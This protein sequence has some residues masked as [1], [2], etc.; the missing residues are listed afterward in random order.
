MGSG[1]A[2]E[3]GEAGH[4]GNGSGHHPD[5]VVVFGVTAQAVR[6]VEHFAERCELVDVVWDRF[7]HD[8]Q[9]LGE[10]QVVRLVKATVQD[11]SLDQ[12]FED[13]PLIVVATGDPRV[14]ARVAARAM[15]RGLAVVGFPDEADVEE[16]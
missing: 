1:E 4:R 5:H 6:V 13:D 3:A 8:L 7:P 14:D 10:G 12:F 11:H 15:R 2:D 16:G 9:M